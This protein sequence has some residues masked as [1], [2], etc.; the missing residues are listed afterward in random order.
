MI[1]TFYIDSTNLSVTK[2]ALIIAASFLT[3]FSKAK[4]YS[5]KHEIDPKKYNYLLGT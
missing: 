4:R 1:Y 5:G 2:I 3:F